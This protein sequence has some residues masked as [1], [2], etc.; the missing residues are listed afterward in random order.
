[1]IAAYDQLT[2]PVDIATLVVP[3]GLYFLVLGLLNSRR[4]PQLLRGRSDFALLLV[5]LSPL[6]ALP[7]ISYVGVSPLTVLAIT[8]VVVGAI[9]ALAPRGETWVIY[10]TPLDQGAR[11]VEQALTAMDL[12]AARNRRGVFRLRGKDATIE[13]S[14]FSLLRN[15]SIRL[16]GGDVSLGRRFEGELAGVLSEI[17]T[18]PSPMGVGLLLVATAM[19]VAPLT[20]VAHRAGEIV[21][22]LTDLLN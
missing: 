1:M 22:I 20:L 11:A 6:F 3:V 13:I 16:R 12:H 2:V 8:A 17:R 7:A 15:V 10:N 14:S 4:H 21:R 9:W 18:E 5:A 19:L